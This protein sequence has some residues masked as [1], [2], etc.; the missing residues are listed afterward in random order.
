MPARWP[1]QPQARDPMMPVPQ[2]GPPQQFDWRQLM[3]QP[4]YT[5]PQQ[6]GFAGTGFADFLRSHWLPR[7]GL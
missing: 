2:M 5:Q 1:M 4:L 3:Q 7:Q 6:Q